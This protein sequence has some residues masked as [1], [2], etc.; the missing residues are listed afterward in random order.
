MGVV[1]GYTTDSPCSA[2]LMW[3]ATVGFDVPGSITE[4]TLHDLGASLRRMSH[5]CAPLT[6][7]IFIVRA[8]LP[9]IG[10]VSDAGIEY[11]GRD[12]GRDRGIVEDAQFKSSVCIC[13]SQ[14]VTP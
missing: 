5:T 9:S 11:G 10:E 1:I 12:V 6:V 7:G 13:A 8:I 4:D 3:V 2:S 14:G